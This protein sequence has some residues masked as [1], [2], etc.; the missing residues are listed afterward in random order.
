MNAPD[1]PLILEADALEPILGN[2]G[3]LV[4]DLTK[5]AT[6]AELH[7][8]GA[9]YLDYGQIIAIR[10]PTMGLLP[11]TAELE[12][13]FSAL[14]IDDSV[15]V[16]AYDDE[17]GGKAGRLLWTLEVMGHTRF[18]LLNGGL[19]AWAN[20]G[21]PLEQTAAT[22]SPRQFQAQPTTDPVADGDY[23][24]QH[25]GDA[26]IALLDA[27][28]ADEY[29][30]VKKYAE[31]AGHIPGAINMD[32][33]LALDQQRNLRL[34]PD[35]DLEQMLTD[36]GIR[37]EHEVITYCHTHHRSSLTYVML[38][39]QGFPRVKGYPGSWSDWGN[40]PDTPIA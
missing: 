24:K 8:P 22:P 4:V 31:K 21:H 28:S 39:A 5:P 36:L 16:V 7:I 18:S 2:S 10:K 20:E 32:W 12:R 30:G 6:Y 23:I 40:R 1:L 9:V 25:L 37:K 3:L 26:G 14:G 33:L 17:G 19:H 35:A 34:K 15:H 11:E 13:I 38:K 29:S 27:R